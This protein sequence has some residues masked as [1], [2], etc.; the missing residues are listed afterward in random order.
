MGAALKSKK[1]KKKKSC[2]GRVSWKLKSLRL[3]SRNLSICIAKGDG[4]KH[5]PHGQMRQLLPLKQKWD[6]CCSFSW[7]VSCTPTSTPTTGLLPHF[8]QSLPRLCSATSSEAPSLF[9][10]TVWTRGSFVCHSL[11][12]HSAPCFFKA[13]ATYRI[14]YFV[15]SLS[16]PRNHKLYRAGVQLFLFTLVLV[17]REEA[18]TS[19]VFS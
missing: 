11:S 8:F 3:S 17:L 13:A 16:P 5:H 12:P 15:C 19:C 9:A 6:T 7:N 18:D 14:C 10:H 1:K 4:H 2:G